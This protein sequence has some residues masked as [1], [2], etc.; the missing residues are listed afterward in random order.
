MQL[1]FVQTWLS[2]GNK[3]FDAAGALLKLYIRNIWTSSVKILNIANT[4]HTYIEFQ[5]YLHIYEIS[6]YCEP[7]WPINGKKR[8]FKMAAVAVKLKIG[9]EPLAQTRLSSLVETSMWR[10]S[11]ICSAV[12]EENI[13]KTHY[14]WRTIETG[15]WTKT[16][17]KISIDFQVSRGKT[18]NRCSLTLRFRRSQY[19]S[20]GCH[21][22]LP[23]PIVH[24]RFHQMSLGSTAALKSRTEKI[25]DF[26]DRK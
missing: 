7:K 10:V 16:P 9:F 2:N 18:V 1:H 24:C 3:Y 14:V 23:K 17:W 19:L 26:T 22:R 13:G 21:G 6:S 11:F 8:Y 25:T 5:Y 12:S 20:D 15:R 4:E